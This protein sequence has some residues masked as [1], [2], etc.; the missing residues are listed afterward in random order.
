MIHQPIPELEKNMD[1]FLLLANECLQ[2]T[3]KHE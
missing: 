1:K 3:N 2:S